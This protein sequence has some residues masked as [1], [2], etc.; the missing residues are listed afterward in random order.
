MTKELLK[1]ASKAYYEGNP[2]MSDEEFDRLADTYKWKDVGYNPDVK[3][4]HV[5]PLFSLQKVFRGEDEPIQYKGEVTITPKLDGAAIALEYKGGSLVRVLTRGNGKEGV[6]VTNKFINSNIVPHN[7]GFN[8]KGV[9]Q[10]TGELVADKEIPNARNYAAGA[11]NLKD[12]KEFVSR[13]LTFIAYGM[14]GQEHEQ[15]YKS[16]SYKQDMEYLRKFGFH[17]ACDSDWDIF[18]NDGS[19]FRVDSNS[20]FKELGYTAHHPRGAYA[21]KE[22]EAGVETILLDVVWQTG[23]S[24][25]VT[26]VAILEPIEIDDA[27]ISRAT[28]NNM[29]YIDELGLEIG[30]RVEVIRAG[31]IIPCVVSRVS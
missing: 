5:F 20:Y 13:D 26:P 22:R 27:Q 28:L 2:I 4:P 21:L 29:A 6:N 15:S 18:P 31:K 16:N 12:T 9:F 30:C 7:I 19:V 23:K 14:R 24:G 17:T 11:L 3:E 10:V 25:K 8:T 1:Q